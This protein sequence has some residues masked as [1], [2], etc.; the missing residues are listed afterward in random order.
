MVLLHTMPLLSTDLALVGIVRQVDSEQLDWKEVTYPQLTAD[1]K[2]IL[3]IVALIFASISVASST[4]VFCWFVKMRRSFRHD[5][6]MLLIQSDMCKALWFMVYPLVVFVNG[7]I[8]DESALCQ[9]SGFF[10][11]VSIEQADIAVLIIAAHSALFIFQRRPQFKE[12]GLYPYRHT[13]YAL[14]CLVP[15]I[16]ASLVFVRG[17]RAF[18][19]EGAYCYL[20]LHPTWYRLALDWI[21]RYI[22]IVVILG[23]YGSIYYY[24]RQ[25]FHGFTRDEREAPNQT[26]SHTHL[27]MPT[28]TQPS[29]SLGQNPD[30]GTEPWRRTEKV[31]LISHHYASKQSDAG[32]AQ[33]VAVT[34]LIPIHELSHVSTT[35]TSISNSDKVLYAEESFRKTSMR[36]M[37][38]AHFSPHSWLEV[39][40][41][42]YLQEDTWWYSGAYR[43]TLASSRRNNSSIEFTYK[44]RRNSEAESLTAPMTYAQYRDSHEQATTMKAEMM[45]TREKIRRQLRVLFIYPLVY[46]GMWIIPFISHTMQY[47]ERYALHPP[48]IL[49]CVT[50]ACICIQAL[51]D[52]LLFSTRDK[53]WQHVPGNDGTFWGSLKFWTG[54]HGVGDMTTFSAGPGKTRDEMVL[55][56]RAAYRR[57]DDEIAQRRNQVRVPGLRCGQ[58]RRLPRCWWDVDRSG[59]AAA[60]SSMEEGILWVGT[61][62]SGGAPLVTEIT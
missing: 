11:T 3:M 58:S 16:M 40:E 28:S 39:D 1:K 23:T 35:S 25:K 55:E 46:I 9:V 42:S 18:V 27:H 20:P 32:M 52:C 17:Q 54:W 33:V 50:T 4:L 2:H 30:L 47:S 37:P 10:L 15:L 56:A 31:G 21:P 26:T 24:V 60:M 22:I 57:R 51:V 62:S 48:F 13:A 41:S 14:W 7:P 34:S 5:L 38:P 19:G 6:I 29:I 53:P 45:V 36:L 61:T 12:G 8:R 43:D 44:P 49:T 59:D